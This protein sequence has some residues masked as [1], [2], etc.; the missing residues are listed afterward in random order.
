MGGFNA[1]SGN[2]DL[3]TVLTP[4]RRDL[5]RKLYVY[6]QYICSYTQ[7]LSILNAKCPVTRFKTDF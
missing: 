3:L 6:V 5:R 2:T 4:N 1:L 7:I